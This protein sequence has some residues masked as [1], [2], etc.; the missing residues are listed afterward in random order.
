M[1]KRKVNKRSKSY[2]KR[3]RR[4]ILFVLEILVLLIL[5]L[6]LAAYVY[7][8][9]KLDSIKTNDLD[10][11]KVKVNEEVIQGEELKGTQLLAL[12][13]LDSRDGNLESGNSDTMMIACIDNDNK[14]VKLVSLYRDTYLKVSDKKY[15]KANSAYALGGPEQ[16]LSMMN[17]NLDLNISDYVTVDFK[18]LSTAIDLL[19]GLDIEMTRDELIHMNNYNKETSKVS[20]V[21]YEKIPVPD[22]GPMDKDTY[23]LNGTQAV[24]YARIRYGGG[25]DFRR[26]S[27]QRIVVEK[28]VEKAKKASLT[29]L[30]KIMD[31]VFPMIS[32][33]LS[34]SEIIN[35][36]MSMLTYDLGEQ[37]GFPFDHLEGENVKDHLDGQDVVLPVTL[38]TNVEKLH[39]FLFPE[40]EYTPSANVHEFSETIIE[41]SGYSEED[42]PSYSEDGAIP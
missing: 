41:K 13:G 36:G 8:N 19:G 23:H 10:L 37:T 7:F 17:Q 27:R 38:E 35:M 5:A 11:D 42:I 30:T 32:T 12:V 18:A 25:N 2:R 31:E 9:K 33:S 3:R 28:I 15:G 16:M 39:E 22:I 40:I 21:E 34:K 24:S 29:T 14:N 4:R 20:G 26:A 1:A 6:V